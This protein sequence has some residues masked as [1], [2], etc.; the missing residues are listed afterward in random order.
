MRYKWLWIPCLVILVTG[1]TSCGGGAGSNEAPPPPPVVP[2]FDKVKAFA[3]LEKQCSF[4][5]R[6]PGSVAHE[7][8]CAWLVEQLN[9]ADKLIQQNF[10][11]ST[12]FGG[13]YDF[14][15]IIAVYGQSKPG[16]PFLLVA[17]WDCRPKAD[18]DPDPAN[19]DK[20]VPGANDGASG[21]SVLLEIARLMK[22]TPPSRPVI[23]AL[24]DAE[25]SGQESSSLQY[26]GF[27]LGSKYLA[28]HWPSGIAKPKEGVLL[29]LVGGDNIPNPRLAPRFGGNNILD[30][31][32]EGYSIN[33]N[34]TLVNALWTIAEQRG[35]SAFVRTVGRQVVDD[36]LPFIAA[37]I[38][39]IDI[40]DFPPPEWHTIDDTPA[41]CSPDALEQSGDTL[42]H[43]L[44]AS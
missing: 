3:N 43:Y 5:P 40:I 25:D 24:V 32:I 35:H 23:I 21:V 8:C 39:V 44:Y 1:C 33:A 13:P 11:T 16:V 27:C 36:H 29:D 19:R 30:F 17:H 9:S 22:A 6:I 42:L 7:Q 28:E 4:G 10:S 38:K 15:N 2:S 41:H 37:G 12:P 26:M 34:A 31:P 20:P 18:Q 14:T